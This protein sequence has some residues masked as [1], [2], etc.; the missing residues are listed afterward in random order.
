MYWEEKYSR[1]FV[2]H[3]LSAI[4]M[5]YIPVNNQ[6]LA[7]PQLALQYGKKWRINLMYR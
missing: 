6:D 5:M 4:S 3:L 7:D 2:E 1:I